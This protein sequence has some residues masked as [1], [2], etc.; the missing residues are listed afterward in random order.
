MN[1]EGLSEETLRKFVE[2]EFIK[3]YTDIFLLE[4]YKNMIENMEE[5]WR[6]FLSETNKLY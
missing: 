1:I 4:Q 6:T 2:K 3:D 5:V